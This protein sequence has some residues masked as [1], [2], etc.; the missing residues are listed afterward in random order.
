MKQRKF[1]SLFLALA[2]VLSMLTGCGST[3]GSASGTQQSASS[4]AQSSAQS[5]AQSSETDDNQAAAEQLLQDLKGTYQELWPVVLSDE[6]HQLWLDDS[7]KLVG[8]DNAEAAVEKISSM[9][10]GTV[11]GEEAAEAYKDGNM[12]YDCEFL[13]DVAQFTFDGATI[14][15]TDENGTEVFRHSYHY[16]GMEEIRGLYIY[17]S[18]D[19]D[20]GEFTYFCMAPDTMATTWHIEFRYGSDLD[21]LKRY[22]AGDYAYWLA[23]GIS[24]DCTAD[25]IENCIQLFCTE[26]LSE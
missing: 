17:E 13:Q 8:E 5:A 26:N 19:A 12:A 25:D 18:D 9:V 22:D 1:A 15:G 23:A 4:S 10:T 3:T 6:Y 11:T 24:V 2:L 21:A 7:A 16:I 14:S 20:S